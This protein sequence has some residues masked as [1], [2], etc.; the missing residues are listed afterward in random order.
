MNMSP[1]SMLGSLQNIYCNDTAVLEKCRELSINSTQIENKK[2]FYIGLSLAVSSSLFIG[3]S[4]IVKKKGLLRISRHGQIR[5]GLGGFGY[6]KEWIWWA[7]LL[8]MGIGEGANF[9]AYAFA[10]ASLV[11]PLGALSVLVSAIL[12]SK[13][14][15]ERINLLGK[16]GCLLC[17]LGSVVIVIHSPGESTVETM[18]DLSIMLSDQYFV[19]YVVIILIAV[20]ILVIYFV[21]KYGN[22]NVL[23][24]IL[25]CSA[26]G[27]LSVMGC[28]G[29]GIALRETFSGEKNDFKN[30]VTWFCLFS[31]IA[32][33]SI[34]MNYLNKALDIFNT[35]I[36]TP[37]YYVFFT[38]FVIIASSILFKEWTS[39]SFEDILGNLSGFLTVICAIFLLNAFKD[40]DVSLS[41]LNNVLRPNGM[42]PVSMSSES[43]AS[44]IIIDKHRRDSSKSHLD[45]LSLTLSEATYGTVSS[46]SYEAKS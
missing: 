8:L 37:I 6:L 4:F 14:L 13:F 20:V 11:T 40:W 17:T 10:P 2:N 3:S 44:S 26:I 19:A 36:V 32:C 9:A 38:T 42:S 16:I 24:Y 34:Q 7:G 29:L 39:L 30:F 41:N 31:V 5:A 46:H 43:V 15:R 18:E 33:I 45:R 12:S 35:S 25:I 23:I 21:P 22:T 28:K 1:S 27:S